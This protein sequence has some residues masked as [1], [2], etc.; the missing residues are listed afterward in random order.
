MQRLLFPLSPRLLFFS[1]L[2]VALLSCKPVWVATYDGALAQATTETAAAVDLF[3]LNLAEAPPQSV[4]RTYAAVSKDYI[5]IEVALGSLLK[6]NQ[7]RSLNTHSIRIGEIM[8]EVW[9]DYKAEHKQD[10]LIS[11]GIIQLNRIRMNDFFH[12]MLVAEKA[13]N[14]NLPN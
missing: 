3:Y 5:E 2:S 10:T 14:M 8:L 6:R 9:R 12:A 13:K 4:G 7:L 11:D 1:V